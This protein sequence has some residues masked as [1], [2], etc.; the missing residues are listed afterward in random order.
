MLWPVTALGAVVLIAAVGFM[1]T[2]ILDDAAIA[3]PTYNSIVLW[4]RRQ[5]HARDL[6]K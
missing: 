4:W 2:G 1:V 5:L 6:A 3:P